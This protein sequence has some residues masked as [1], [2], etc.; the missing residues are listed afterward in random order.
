MYISDT[1]QAARSVIRQNRAARTRLLFSCFAAFA[2]IS[3]IVVS[4]LA[5]SWIYHWLV[6]GQMSGWEN[7]AQV[8][9]AIAL[10]ML[11]PGV[12]RRDYDIVRFL[13]FR[14]HADR[15]FQ[16]WNAAFISAITLSFLAKTSVVYSRGAVVLF[17]V[18]G[19][20]AVVATRFLLVRLVQVASK[21]GTVTA[22]R[23]LLVGH[24]REVIGFARNRQPW[25]SGME[26]VGVG[27][28]PAT[29]EPGGV[30]FDAA[31]EEAVQR[32][33]LTAPD[34]IFLLL[35]WDRREAIERAV[36]GFLTIP[37]SI[38]LGAETVVERFP[39][40]RVERTGDL[41]SLQIV[42]NPLS[43]VDIALKRTFDVIIAGAALLALALPMALIALAIRMDTPGPVLFRQRRYGFNQRPFRIFKFRTMR[44]LEDGPV[45]RQA[46]AN[47]PRVTRVGR[48]LRRWNLDEL[49]QLLN[50]L[51]GHMSLVGPRPHA[52]AHDHEYERRI[53]LYARRHNVRPGITGW[54]QVNGFRGETATDDKMRRRIDHDLQYIDNWSLW[55]DLRILLLTVFSRKAYRNAG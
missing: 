49:P 31:L 22:R 17:Y 10:F 27:I 6:L 25:N 5:V 50:V 34:D 3:V 42:R 19:Y 45:V 26:I 18:A 12:L 43:A 37:A 1:A 8:G 53:A 36:D 14:G 47:D 55:L 46:S 33:R 48:V 4:A 38:H 29:A 24:D 13:D 35:P 2:D 40:L 9:A 23:I 52:L 30:A 32:A 41:T 21:T 20:V 7:Q 54:A 28:L 39:D 51:M 44:V 15:A 11:V 16:L